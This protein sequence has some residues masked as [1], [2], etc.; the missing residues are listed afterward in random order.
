MDLQT[1]IST[2]TEGLEPEQAKIVKAAIE[3]DAVKGKIEPTLKQAREYDTLATREADLKAQLD[4]GPNKPGAKAYQEWY[5]KNFAAGQK[6]Q[7]DQARY[8]EKYGTLEAPKG[9]APAPV[10]A[11]G[12]T[13]SD[14]DIARMVD[15][16]IQEGYAP[17]WSDLLTNTGTI[18]QKHMFAGRKAPIDF[19]KVSELAQQYGGDLERAY[20]E[21]DKPEREKEAKVAQD[22]EIDRRVTEELQKRG[23]S[24]HFPGGAD[25][26]PGN[27]APGRD[28]SKFNKAA[29][30]QE[31]VKTYVTGQ[32][33][34]PL[35]GF[36]VN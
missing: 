27:L 31:L 4:G 25:A 1:F 17:R 3:R 12:K 9:D 20:D 26:T 33:Q 10:P 30:E 35:T 36:G 6:L 5:E 2:L 14:E 11:T 32:E 18:V 7:A 34:E 16:R 21:W 24:Q 8:V 15:K 19:K 29:L 13:Y 22:K 28:R 23:A